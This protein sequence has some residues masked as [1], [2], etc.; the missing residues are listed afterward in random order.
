MCP[1]KHPSAAFEYS[2]YP[3]RAIARIHLQ[4]GKLDEAHTAF[5]KLEE[6][7]KEGL[8]RWYAKGGLGK[9][10]DRYR[11]W[12]RSAMIG[13]A[14]VMLRKSEFE[15]MSTL[16][17]ETSKVQR[18]P[19]RPA[20]AAAKRASHRTTIEDLLRRDWPEEALEQ[21]HLL[22]VEFPRNKMQGITEFLRAKAHFALRNFNETRKSLMLCLRLLDPRALENA[23]VRYL[24]AEAL[25]QMDRRAEADALFKKFIEV[26][27]ESEFAALAQRR[28]ELV[29][30]IR[31]DLGWDGEPFLV[32]HKR[33]KSYPLV[34]HVEGYGGNYRAV[35]RWTPLI[36]EIPIPASTER[37]RLRFRK[38][39]VALVQIND[40]NFWQEPHARRTEGV[41]DQELL[42]ADPAEW[43]SGKIK[44]TFR[45][46]LNYWPYWDPESLYVNWLELELLKLD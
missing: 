18:R 26:Y 38:K 37:I 12:I 44:I 5:K 42:I 43:A 36:Y 28:L 35:H 11:Y 8:S 30:V 39:G 32:Q 29:S 3:S 34:A 2:A 23:E 1:E 17:S 7:A 14:G 31:L 33:I 40:K 4:E 20:L 15:P 6:D 24:N 41:V 27:P 22:E 13:Q 9:D 21:L 19:M 10:A 46:G 16:C 45:D 25:F